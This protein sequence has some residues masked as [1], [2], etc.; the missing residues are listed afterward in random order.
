MARIFTIHGKD[1]LRRIAVQGQGCICFVVNSKGMS[2]DDWIHDGSLEEILAPVHSAKEQDAFIKDNIELIGDLNAALGRQ[3]LW[4]ATDISSRNRYMSV[5]PDYLEELCWILKTIEHNPQASLLIADPSAAIQTTVRQ[6]LKD[7]GRQTCWRIPS[8]NRIMNSAVGR[9]KK[10]GGLFANACIFYWRS[11]QA[12]VILRRSVEERAR[13]P[14]NYYVTKTFS[15]ENSWDKEGRY[16][17]TIF[18]SLSQRLPEYKNVLVWTFHK[19]NYHGF[20]KRIAADNKNFILPV[21][22]FLNLTDVL[23]ILIEVLFFRIKLPPMTYRGLDV[24]GIVQYEL[25]R[26]R[27]GIQFVQYMHYR[28]TKNLLKKF[29]VET[30]LMT[31]ENNPWERLCTLAIRESKASI[32]ILG[33]EHSVV[34]QASLNMFLTQKEE[35]IAPLPDRILTVGRIPLELLQKHGGKRQ[36]IQT[37]CALRYEYLVKARRKPRGHSKRV[38]VALDGVLQTRFLLEYIFQEVVKSPEYEFVLR[39]HP[40]L[41]WASLVKLYGFTIQDT[42]NVHISKGSL[43]EDLANADVLIYWQSTVA[44]EALSMGLPL[45]NFSPQSVLSYDPLYGTDNLKWTVG[46]KDDLNS[47]LVAID[48]LSE[49]EFNRQYDLAKIFIGEYFYP[50]TSQGIEAFVTG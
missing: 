16:H 31:Y 22:F 15:Y 2:L 41:P 49:D 39:A 25:T 50:V 1:V 45:I 35:E 7:S 17:D 38:L 8:V 4:W 13:C 32:Q 29:S 42:G 36:K 9:I 21:E 37:S 19:E 33:Y 12:R 47:R 6:F 44:L 46:A 30:F 11:L 40:A 48:T 18:G 23:G 20:L 10:I 5:I 3:V 24:S 43:K 28:A 34:P 26:T 27:N 14:K